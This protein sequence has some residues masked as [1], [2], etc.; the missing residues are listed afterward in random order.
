MKEDIK[1]FLDEMNKLFGNDGKDG[2]RV[3][4]GKDLFVPIGY[5]EKRMSNRPIGMRAPT[6]QRPKLRRAPC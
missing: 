6:A 5:H 2:I 3:G 1:P 4:N